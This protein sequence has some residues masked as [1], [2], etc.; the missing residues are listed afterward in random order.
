MKDKLKPCPFCGQNNIMIHNY[1]KEN[2]RWSVDHYCKHDVDDLTI[3]ID[4]Y[5]YSREEVV[6][7]WNRRAKK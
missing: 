2:N 5:G 4:V 1:D 3:V 6:E 7:M